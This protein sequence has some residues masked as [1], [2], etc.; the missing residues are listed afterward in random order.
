MISRKGIPL[1]V[2]CL[3]VSVSFLQA[4]GQSSKHGTVVVPNSSVE[5]PGDSSSDSQ[6]S[7]SE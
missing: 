3:L 2:M 4:Q 1:V 6:V 5:H 7:I